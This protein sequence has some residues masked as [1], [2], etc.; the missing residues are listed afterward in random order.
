M[1]KNRWA[2][3][4]IPMALAV[5][6]SGCSLLGSPSSAQPRV[7][8]TSATAALPASVAKVA[9]L[10]AFEIAVP[11]DLPPGMQATPSASVIALVSGSS[12]T[13][14]RALV[15]DYP[16]LKPGNPSLEVNESS[17]AR[18]LDG[19]GV[20]HVTVG[21]YPAQ[22]KVLSKSGS[23]LGMTLYLRAHGVSFTLVAQGITKSKL[24]AIARTLVR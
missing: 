17:V 19:S 13:A 10:V 6:I 3:G 7:S 14:T 16:P 8:P 1:T 9:N 18:P 15:L 11:A 20:E 21:G 4:V 24:L 5:L 2:W 12:T 22:L 23:T